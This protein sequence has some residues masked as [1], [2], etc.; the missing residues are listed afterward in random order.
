MWEIYAVSRLP[1]FF[2]FCRTLLAGVGLGRLARGQG[3]GSASGVG[4]GGRRAYQSLHGAVQSVSVVA[5]ELGVGTLERRVSHGLR[6]L[7]TIA[8]SLLAL[9]VL[10]RVLGL[11]ATNEVSTQTS[12]ASSGEGAR[13]TGHLDG[14]I[15][16]VTGW[17]GW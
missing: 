13:H 15:W 10:G 6:L 1:S 14:L 8:V 9:V 11:C 17:F 2:S 16:A 12:E 5:A 3:P 4:E 7:D